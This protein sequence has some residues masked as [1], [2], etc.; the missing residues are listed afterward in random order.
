MVIILNI[1][2][3]LFIF[4]AKII[5]NALATFRLIIVANGKKLFGAFLNAIIAIIWIIS[6]SLV[7]ININK[8]PF[9]III[10]TIGSFIGSYIGSIMEEKL[11]LGSNMLF[12]IAKKEYINKINN[13]L[14]KLKYITYNLTN[15]N[16][17]M[18][19]IM[20]ER[21]KRTEILNIIRN[22]DNQAIIISEVARQLVFK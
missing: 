7:I 1:L 18:I 16:Q 9:K 2:I 8:N 3:Y 11:A 15:E 19:L 6:T 22:I 10:F 12:I 4:F 20:V 21:K 17:S 14:N 13:K 5:E